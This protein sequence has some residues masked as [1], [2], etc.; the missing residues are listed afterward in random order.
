M[1]R[2]ATRQVP[3]PPNLM[4]FLRDEGR[5]PQLLQEFGLLPKSP[6]PHVWKTALRFNAYFVL[7]WV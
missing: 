6:S 4:R 1:L 5:E 3:Q 7:L 2:R